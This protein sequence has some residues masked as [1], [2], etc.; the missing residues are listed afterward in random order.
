MTFK[1][2][3][4]KYIFSDGKLISCVINFA[5]ENSVIINLKVR[6]QIEKRY[7][8]CL[9]ELKFQN[10]IEFNLFENFG[11]ENYTD[12]TFVKLETGEYYISLDPYG[13]LNEKNEHD[14]FVVKAKAVEII[15]K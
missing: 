1:E 8:E 4:S 9:L 3:I 12:I 13:N 11:T 2:T 7:K 5:N 10:V 6:K 14:N 15:E